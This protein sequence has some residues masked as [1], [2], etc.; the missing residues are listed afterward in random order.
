MQKNNP[1]IFG[2]ACILVAIVAVSSLVGYSSF[3]GASSEKSSHATYHRLYGAPI[4]GGNYSFTPPTS[5]YQ[6]INT[7][8]ASD[9]W[10]QSDLQNMTVHVTLGQVIFFNNVTAREELEFTHNHNITLNGYPNINL[11]LTYGGFE[12]LEETNS[13]ATNYHT[14]IDGGISLRYIWT[15]SVQKTEGMTMPPWGYYMV[16]AE[17]GELM[18]L[19]GYLF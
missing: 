19:Q 10:T 11:N 15:I 13:S 6:A 16:D 3:I 8:L 12:H 5:K 14:I 18:P 1:R 4:V 17:T 9:N 7:A 2:V